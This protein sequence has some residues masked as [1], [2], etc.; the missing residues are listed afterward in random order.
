M[1]NKTETKNEN[2]VTRRGFWTGAIY[3][4]SA[5]ATAILGTTAARF[6]AFPLLKKESKAKPEEA[7]I[8]VGYASQFEKGGIPQNAEVVVEG[9]RN[10][11]LAEKKTKAGSVW[12]RRS[13][14]GE[15][16]AFSSICPHLGCGIQFDKENK[17]FICPCHDSSYDLAGT[18]IAGPAKR[19]LDRLE[20]IEND[21]RVQIKFQQFKLDVAEK[22]VV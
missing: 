13:E 11:W 6:F 5:M 14:E 15:I 21:G 17:N 7:V 1:E 19:G 18:K 8:D 16:Q 10:A 20:V 4:V 12:V 22:E 2:G 3:G 9:R